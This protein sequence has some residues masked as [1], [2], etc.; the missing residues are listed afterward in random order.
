VIPRWAAAALI[1]SQ[2][3]HVVVAVVVPNHAV[4]GLAWVL[5]AVGFAAAVAVWADRRLPAHGG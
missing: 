2:P 3:L 4:D 1:V 5:T